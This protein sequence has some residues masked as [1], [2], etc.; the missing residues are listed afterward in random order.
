MLDIITRKEIK[1]KQGLLI[2]KQI[3]KMVK[4]YWKGIKRT[5]SISTYTSWKQGLLINK[6]INWWM[7]GQEIKRTFL[8]TRLGINANILY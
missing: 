4:R 8:F 1:L 3:F 6:Y 7:N 2:P 5:F